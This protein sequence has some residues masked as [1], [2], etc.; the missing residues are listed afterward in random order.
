M[1]DH[2][3]FREE[4]PFNHHS[5][6]VMDGSVGKNYDSASPRSTVAA[7]SQPPPTSRKRKQRSLSPRQPDGVKTLIEHRKNRRN[8]SSSRSDSYWIW[9]RAERSYWDSLSTLYLTSDALRDLNRQNVVTKMRVHDQVPDV[10]SR[11]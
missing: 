9:D 3:S 5:V 10:D 7:D 8:S 11:V 4:T 1:H 2:S 6:R